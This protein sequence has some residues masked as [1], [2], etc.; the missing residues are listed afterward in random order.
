MESST[1]ALLITLVL[2]DDGASST[3]P[4]LLPR[5]FVEYQP[6]M[7]RR[8]ARNIEAS[9]V[10]SRVWPVLPSMPANGL[11]ISLACSSSAGTFVRLG[12]KLQYGACSLL[13]T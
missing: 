6:S 2:F 5:K 8:R 12:V 10:F 9:A 4:S 7:R 3:R 13:A 11:P 1:A